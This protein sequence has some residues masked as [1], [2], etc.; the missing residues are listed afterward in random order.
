MYQQ[1]C[2]RGELS[3]SPPTRCTRPVQHSDGGARGCGRE[4]QGAQPA[5][6]GTPGA[7]GEPELTES[8]VQRTEEGSDWSEEDA[9]CKE[10]AADLQD[11]RPHFEER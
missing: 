7:G 1:S 10:Q 3:D 4:K 5:E 8:R 6:Q 9:E 2:G 11:E